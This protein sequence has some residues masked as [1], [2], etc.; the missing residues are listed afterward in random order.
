MAGP[1][2]HGVTATM[3][4]Q[5]ATTPSGPI[6]RR[7]PQDDRLAQGKAANAGKANPAQ[8][9]RSRDI[10]LIKD[11]FNDLAPLAAQFVQKIPL[12]NGRGGIDQ[13][14]RWA[15]QEMGRRSE[16]AD[17]PPSPPSATSTRS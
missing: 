11:I 3:F 6:S 4:G 12:I 16:A 8:A 9:F 7:L 1:R 2:K 13:D 15:Y 17:E 10:W 14:A 5:Q